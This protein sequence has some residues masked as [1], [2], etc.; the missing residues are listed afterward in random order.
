MND[1]YPLTRLCPFCGKPHQWEQILDMHYGRNWSICCGRFVLF[2][3]YNER[4]L[5]EIA[6]L[7]NNR[8]EEAK[9]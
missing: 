1:I 7:W 2:S 4:E 6:D 8:P 3:A 9:P 5:R